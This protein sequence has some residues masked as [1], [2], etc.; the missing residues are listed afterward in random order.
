MDERFG[1]NDFIDTLKL[2]GELSLYVFTK[3][4]SRNYESC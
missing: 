2:G 3:E 4:R 1:K